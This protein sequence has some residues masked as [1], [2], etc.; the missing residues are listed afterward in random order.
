M[1][2]Q[3]VIYNPINN[4]TLTFA[5]N[6]TSNTI[7]VDVIGET[8]SEIDE[9]FFVNLS[10]PSNGVILDGQGVGTITNDDAPPIFISIDD[11]TQV[12]G[13]SGTTAF[14]FTVTLSSASSQTITVGYATADD[15]ASGTGNPKDYNKINNGTLT[16]NPGETIQTITVFVNG[17]T[18]A[19]PNETFFVDLSNAVGAVLDDDQGLGTILDD[20]SIFAP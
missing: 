10:N 17:D 7:T 6:E 19:E 1:W 15:T 11:V 5:P 16:F 14:T 3:S 20:D 8:L 4:G 13:D 18:T 2:L 12:E 9:T